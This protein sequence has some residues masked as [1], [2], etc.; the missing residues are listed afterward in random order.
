VI[1]RLKPECV[2]KGYLLVVSWTRWIHSTSSYAIYRK[3]VLILSSHTPVIPYDE[4]VSYYCLWSSQQWRCE[5]KCRYRLS[6]CRQI[7][8]YILNYYPV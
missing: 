4:P 8:N 7:T 6:L 3:P 1:K 2:H 5:Y